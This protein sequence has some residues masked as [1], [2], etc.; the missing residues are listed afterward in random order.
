MELTWPNCVPATDDL[1][2]DVGI[3]GRLLYNKQ[4]LSR[5]QVFQLLHFGAVFMKYNLASRMGGGRGSK[6][7]SNTGCAIIFLHFR[8]QLDF[9]QISIARLK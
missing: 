9:P 5:V 3:I 1:F 2:L 8:K 6:K 7:W 4:I